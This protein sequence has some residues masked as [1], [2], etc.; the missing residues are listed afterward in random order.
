MA[1]R[2]PF[3]RFGFGST[4]YLFSNVTRWNDNFRAKKSQ[5]QRLMGVSGGV[6][7]Y[8][9]RST[10]S[11]VGV[12]NITVVLAASTP[13]QMQNLR[14]ALNT[15]PAWG[16]Q[17]LFMQPSDS[18]KDLRWCMARCLD[19]PEQQEA[20]GDTDYLQEVKLKFEVTDPRWLS[21]PGTPWYWDDGTLWGAK[22]WVTPRYSSTSVN[23]S[24]TISLTNNGNTPT[25][26]VMRIAATADVT[27]FELGLLS[28]TGAVLNGFRYET[29]LA[30]ATSDLLTVD[31]ESLSVLHDQR[32]GAG[33]A[34]GYPYF[35]RLGG[36]G[37]ITLPPGT[38][39]LDVNGTFTSNVT[40]E[41]EYY[42]GWV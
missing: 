1:E 27:N 18:A 33:I 9:N 35:T 10:P 13:A 15:L 37:F 16:K 20:D 34:S 28:A 23:A 26:L 3:L 29:T 5:T 7:V 32:T 25:P 22:S 40:V 36:N 39:A 17:P 38:W 24:T 14:D 6:D 21:W 42:D 19:V 12:V 31:G 4:S 11:D 30:S 8:G 2:S 41:I